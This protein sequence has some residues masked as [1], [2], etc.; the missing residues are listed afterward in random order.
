MD[1]LDIASL[2]LSPALQ[3]QMVAHEYH[4]AALYA[5]VFK[6]RTAVGGAARITAAEA[7]I[8]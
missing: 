7:C 5:T 1:G 8:P 2:T 3:R 6:L 4:L